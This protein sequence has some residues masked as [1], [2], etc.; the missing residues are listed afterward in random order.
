MNNRTNT[1]LAAG[2][3]AALD[4]DAF[5]AALLQ[6]QPP[7]PNQPTSRSS[8][9]Q[10]VAGN[11]SLMGS[12]AVPARRA[13][14]TRGRASS[15]RGG[16]SRQQQPAGMGLSPLANQ[17]SA[18]V[19]SLQAA[20]LQQQPQRTAGVAS[21]GRSAGRGT[22][23]RAGA[24]TSAQ[25]ADQ[26]AALASLLGIGAAPAAAAPA[27]APRQSASVRRS[28]AAG[29]AGGATNVGTTDNLLGQQGRGQQQQ[30]QALPLMPNTSLLAS[31][32]N[33]NVNPLAVFGQQDA[34]NQSQQR[35][36]RRPRPAAAAG[37][38]N[39]PRNLGAVNF[40]DGM[41]DDGNNL[42]DDGANS[43]N[44]YLL[45]DR[46]G[47]RQ[48]PKYVSDGAYGAALKA[49][50]AGHTDIYL[51]DRNHKAAPGG[52]V[53]SYVGGS[54]P[55]T[56]P[57][58]FTMKHGITTKPM[59]KSRGYVDLDANYRPMERRSAAGAY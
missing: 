33:I 26:Q 32:S 38:Q 12:G 35:V 54:A 37:V 31:N 44:K 3:R 49:A 24:R 15:T 13:A 52:R 45:V 47:Y 16:L 51:W 43:K 40:A 41:G 28:R 39:Q 42:T 50:T 30:R 19:P 17:Q 48:G 57:S 27:S 14:A 36:T 55:I 9:S 34:L 23:Q 11:A 18:N 5:V 4:A 6:Q 25:A 46:E 58:E 21:R 29:T 59:V 1:P 22:A 20:S 2:N 7:Q 53:Y 56:N 8:A 10:P